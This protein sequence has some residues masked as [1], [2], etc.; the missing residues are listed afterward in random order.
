MHHLLRDIR[1]ALRGLRAAPGASL[2]TLLTIAI[3]VAATTT[4]LSVANVL[5]FRAPAGVRDAGGLVTVHAVSRDGSGFH[6]FSWLDWRDM[7]AA[8][9]GLSD[10][11]GVSGFPAS[12]AVGDEPRLGMGM[13]VSGNYWRMLGTRPA[14]GRFFGPEED[15]PGA[16]QVMVLSW[17]AWQQQFGGDSGVVG[18]DVRVNG[19]LFTIIGVAERGF[20][21]HSSLLDVSVLVP[22]ALDPVV[23][24]RDIIERRNASFLE[25]VGRLSPQVS[26]EQV[27]TA[28]T[29]AY[30]AGRAG[31]RSEAAVDVRRWAA[32]PADTVTAVAG[33]MGV[34][35][36][37]AT[38]ILLIASANVANVLLAR[39]AARAREIAVRLAIGASRS[40]LVRQLVTESVVLFAAGGAAGTLIAHWTTRALSGMR[41]PVGI[42]LVLDFPMDLRVLA[43]AL[44]VT[45]VV[46][47]AFGL[48]PALQSTRPDLCVALKE[49]Q[50]LARVGRLRLRGGF[51]AA[52]VAGSVILLV[53][54]GLFVRALGRAGQIDVGFEPADVHALQFELE[55]RY[56]DAAQAP[57]LIARIEERAAALPGVVSTGS[58]RNIP[59]TLSRSETGV[60]IPGRPEEMGV[61]LFQSDFSQ[62]TPGYFATVGIPILRGRPFSGAD[63]AGAPP[64]AIV[65]E[66]L[67]ARVWPGE[68]PVGK[69]IGFGFGGEDQPITV[70]GLARNANYNRLGEDP[71]LMVYVPFSQQPDRSMS[72]LI[73]TAPGTPS[74]ARALAGLVK[75]V[76]PFLPI[77]QNAPLPQLVG[78][79]LLPNRLALSVALL[80][81]ATGLLLAAV[82]LY[83]L[84]AFVVSRRRREIGIRMALGATAGRV[85]SMIL[86]DG[87]RPVSIGLGV[88]FLGAAVL[89]RFLA[90]LLYG[91]SPLDPVTYGAIALL[92]A[93]VGLVASLAP[94]RRAVTG[95]PVDVLRQD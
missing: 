23:S 93:A 13:T 82:G 44:A 90:S 29:A 19:E 28:L 22:L 66:T 34:L 36:A 59:L 57:P 81:G 43:L 20:R 60:R 67:A 74:P 58:V 61:G 12:L 24:H 54:A 5:L 47:V 41:P 38:L 32:V 15:F 3:G 39:A 40:R 68:D 49:Q 21:G 83:G 65:N 79:A 1:F 37:L 7:A 27:R 91:L 46:G 14:L 77:V 76:D 45:L 72:V 92:L 42:P 48:V 78:L 31:E 18:R 94:A 89:G 6:A 9:S 64:V 62:V 16:P 87:M 8:K 69:V 86:R 73:R 84:L 50:S 63:R 52:Q 30:L 85:R 75:E 95:D 26:V 55:V 53:A 88:G 71:L 17:S 10:L 35:L 56:P 25:M 33:F 70:V 80:F 11:A 4:V 2:V 51:V